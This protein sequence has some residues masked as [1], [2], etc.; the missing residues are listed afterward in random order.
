[1]QTPNE[2]FT[3]YDR[4]WIVRIQPPTAPP[5]HRV[6]LLLHGWTGDE[7]VM[8]V[9]TRNL[10]QDIWFFAPRAPHPANSSYGGYSWSIRNEQDPA[11]PIETFLPPAASILSS[12]QMWM[13][14]RKIPAQPIHLMGF[15]Q[16]A[17]L[18]YTLLIQHSTQIGQTAA[19]AGMLP[20]G[21]TERLQSLNL[22][23]KRVL[24]T[25]GTK[26][27]TIPVDRAREAAKALDTAGAEVTY[28]EDETGHKLGAACYKSLAA[29]FGE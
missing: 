29:F 23:G 25:H 4:G 18:A 28:C 7:T 17:A 5:P 21:A 26:D 10:P 8:W 27:A 16:G 15:S 12:V 1:M 13:Q 2:P 14:E 24:I 11:T 20:P 22:T 3:L 9:F 6:M 19:L